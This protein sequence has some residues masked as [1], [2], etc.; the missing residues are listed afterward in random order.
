MVTERMK[1]AVSFCEEWLK[2]DYNGNINDYDEVSAFL[3]EYL[4]DAKE[5]CEE[6]TAEYEAYKFERL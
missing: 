3:K 6:I 5:I 1:H 2:I 4:S